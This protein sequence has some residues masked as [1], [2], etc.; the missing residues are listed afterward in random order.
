MTTTT[1][2]VSRFAL[3]PTEQIPYSEAAFEAALDRKTL[4]RP[5]PAVVHANRSQAEPAYSEE[6][7]NANTRHWFLEIEQQVRHY[8]KLGHDL[9]WVV[10]WT[11][12]W[13]YGWLFRD[14]DLIAEICELDLTYKDPVSFG[15]TLIG[16]QEFIDYNDAFFEAIPDWRYDPLPGESFLNV[17]PDGDVRMTVRYVGTGHW[18]GALKLYPFDRAAAAMPGTGAF[19]QAAAV[20][21]YHFN[22]A[23]KL[24]KGESL[25]DAFDAMQMS[26][27]LP[28][29]DS[30]AFR[31]IMGAARIPA[32]AARLRNRLPGFGA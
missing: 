22:A 19:M 13:W 14:M 17:T 7:L 18:D 9:Q 29:D 8:E 32:A 26:G 23:G 21:R 28:K 2:F 31:S 20:D 6:Q 30:I 16:F 15:R 12:K 25:W 24:Y 3:P 5:A 4:A 1:K 11:K 27:L 10:D